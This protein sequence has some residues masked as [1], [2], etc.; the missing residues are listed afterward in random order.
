MVGIVR[1]REQRYY[2]DDHAVAVPDR[3]ATRT[4]SSSTPPVPS[5][6]RSTAWAPAITWK[7]DAGYVSVIGRGWSREQAAELG[8]I[9]ARVTRRPAV[10]RSPMRHATACRQ[11]YRGPVARHLRAVHVTDRRRRPSPCPTTHSPDGLVRLSG[12]VA[13]PGGVPATRFF[14]RGLRPATVGGRSVLEGVLPVT[15]TVEGATARVVVWAD[16]DVRLTRDSPTPSRP[17]TPSTIDELVAATHR[18]DR[19]EWEQLLEVASAVP[20]RALGSSPRA[21][22]GRDLD[23]G[24]RRPRRSDVRRRRRWPRGRPASD[25]GDAF[26][27]GRRTSGVGIR[28]W[29]WS[30]ALNTAGFGSA[31]SDC[32]TGSSASAC[33][34][35]SSTLPASPHSIIETNRSVHTWADAQIVPRAAHEHDREQERVLATEHREV[36]GRAPQQLERVEVEAGGRL[37]DARRCSGARAASSTPGGREV[38]AGAERDVV[39]HH[40]HRRRVGHGA[41]VG[42]DAG[43]GRPHVIRHDDR[44]PRTA[45]ACPRAPRTFAMVVAVLLVPAPTISCASRAT[46]TAEHASTTARFSAAVSGRRLARWSRGARARRRRRRGSGARAR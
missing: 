11:L 24:R 21:R 14:A 27:R 46:Q 10:T 45:R 3:R 5:A 32:T 15:N 20:L 34:R 4:R 8:D 23:V 29:A 37:L 38:A 16:G 2:R 25:S 36:G 19:A 1:S 17:P 43:L 12:S 41:E 31:N 6:P 30:T 35:P 44:A 9:A 13:A 39:E 26:V 40:R 33:A 18:L 28:P 22:A 42:D 7:D